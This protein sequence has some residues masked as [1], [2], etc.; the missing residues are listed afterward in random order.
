[1]SVGRKL[2]SGYDNLPDTYVA[3][4]LKL[5]EELLPFLVVV[6]TYGFRELL[7]SFLLLL[8]QVP[9]R[10]DIDG[11]ILITP[12]PAVEFR[13]ALALQ[14]EG[15]AGLGALRQVILH[16][17]VNGG[18]LQLRAQNCLCE[19][20]GRLTE[21]GGALP[22]EQLVG[23]DRNGDEQITGRAAVLAGVALA[24][25]GDGLAIVDTCGDVGLNGP[26]LAL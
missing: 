12:A 11:H 19:G 5:L 8:V 4:L 13:N 25:D 1:M 21:D 20:D 9:G 18:D 22:A 7:Q 24:P 23:P 15:G 26:A 16:L 3:S 14:P 10:F 17:A 2:R 6:L